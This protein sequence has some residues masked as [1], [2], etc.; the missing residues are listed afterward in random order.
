LVTFIKTLVASGVMGIV[1][2][3]G[4][5]WA[6]TSTTQG[7]VVQ[8]AIIAMLIGAGGTTFF[9]M[10]WVLRLDEVRVLFRALKRR[11][12]SAAGD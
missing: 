6:S 8:A 1:C 10:A 9:A 5:E 11:R 2:F 7:K 12:N 4:M 3:C